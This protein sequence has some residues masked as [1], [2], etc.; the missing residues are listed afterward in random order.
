MEDF[1]IHTFVFNHFQENTY[2][3]INNKTKTCAIV[4][5]GCFF[6]EE[7]KQLSDFIQNNSLTV[8]KVLYTHCHLDH[9]FGANYVHHTYPNTPFYAHK[10]EEFFISDAINQSLRFGISM[11]QPPKVTH[12]IEDGDTL[13]LGDIEFKA[14]HVPGHSPGSICYYQKE[15]NTLICGDVLFAGSVGRSDLPGG[16]HDT[17][18]QGIM[19]KLMVLPDNVTVY[20]GHGPTTTI[21]IERDTNPYL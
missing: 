3:L 14:I 16:N 9:A 11:E 20:T 5:P 15:S 1:T 13:R 10:D 7:K 18:I 8:E 19:Q 6:D 4:D 12:F 2:I 21:Q 17:L